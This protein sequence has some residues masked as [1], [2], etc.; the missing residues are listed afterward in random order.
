MMERSE[1]LR[2]FVLLY[3]QAIASGDMGFVERHLSRQ[4]DLLV[5]GADLCA[6]WSGYA[7]AIGAF[8]AQVSDVTRGMA[9]IAGDPQAYREGSVGWSADHVKIRLPD[10]TE[11]PCRLTMVWHQ[12][13]GRWKIVQHHLSIGIGSNEAAGK[14]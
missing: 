5:I 1:E 7:A 4:D 13:N 3:C 10:G 8:T 2:D 14:P 9:L 11:I 6:W 12:E